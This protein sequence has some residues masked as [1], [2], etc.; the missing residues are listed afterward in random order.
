MENSSSGQSADTTG[1]SFEMDRFKHALNSEELAM[2][3]GVLDTYC[4]GCRIEPAT[5]KYH[6]LAAVLFALFQR[7][8]TTAD[9]LTKRLASHQQ[10]LAQSDGVSPASDIRVRPID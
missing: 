9:G 8:E 4:D 5:I 1:T 2:I 10:R 7:G 6:D 3:Q